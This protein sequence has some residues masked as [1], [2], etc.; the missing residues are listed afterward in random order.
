MLNK[1]VNLCRIVGAT[2]GKGYSETIYQEGIAL[3]L[4]RQ[5]I[6]YSKEVILPI[7]YDNVIIGNV[8][9]DIVLPN[10]E[11]VIECKA[12]DANL[13]SS[14][15]PQLINYL[16]ITQYKRGILVNFNQ[17]PGKDIVEV[18]T[19]E[20]ENKNLYKADLENEK[21]MYLTDRGFLTTKQEIITTD[22]KKLD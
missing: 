22:P 4:R 10:D 5:N 7:K 11:I 19:V 20:R 6:E 2:L 18:I 14:H 12:I 13:K 16:E 21:I 3:T 1:I 15:I 9:A 17:N 8:R